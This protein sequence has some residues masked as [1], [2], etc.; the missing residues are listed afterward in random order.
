MHW[1]LAITLFLSFFSSSFA[2]V[3]VGLFAQR[4]V[5]MIMVSPSD[6]NYFLLNEKMD[7]VYRFRTDDALSIQAVGNRLAI[8]S[9]YGFSDTLKS[10]DLMGSGQKPSFIVRIGTESKD[11]NYF[12]GLK[13]AAK[14]S[15]LSISN[16]VNMER[17]VSRVVVS[18]VGYGA[19][20]EYYK[21]QS[22][23]CRTYA[24]RHLARH[25]GEGFDLCDN[26]HCQVFSG[27]KKETN[28]VVRATAS[29]N[30]LVMIDPKDQLILS[31]FHAN[32]GG[33]T[34]NSEYVWKEPRTY[35][36]S[37]EDTFCHLGRSSNWQKT[38]PIQDFLAQIGF[39][40]NASGFGNFEFK[41]ED[42]KKQFVLGSDSLETVEMRKMLQLRSAFFDVKF[43][44]GNAVFAGRGYGHGVGLCQQGSMKMAEFGYTYSQI[45]GYYYK[46]VSLVPLS[47]LP[48]KK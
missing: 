39:S 41:Q 5:S 2:Q 40:E 16:R 6:G 7:T 34:A 12:D 10:A 1:A 42:R 17:Y 21:I 9:V 35:L 15:V 18:E 25:V 45:L 4:Q 20:E 22:I 8:K 11:H 36:V 48:G 19:N 24:A 29:T 37:V 30:G 47:S 44:D 46:G 32:C 3:N 23:I 33:Q 27:F 26:E 13:V 38:M 14:N 31:A 43:Q 28:E